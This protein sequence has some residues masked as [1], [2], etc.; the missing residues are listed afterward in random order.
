MDMCMIQ[1]LCPHYIIG[2]RIRTQHRRMLVPCDLYVSCT[3]PMIHLIGELEL[4]VTGKEN[5]ACDLEKVKRIKEE[6]K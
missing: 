1:D 5:I 6:I 2:D 3:C 4:W